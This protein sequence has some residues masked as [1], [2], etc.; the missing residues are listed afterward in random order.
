MDI[1]KE[2]KRMQMWY[3]ECRESGSYYIQFKN[4]ETTYQLGLD[5]IERAKNIAKLAKDMGIEIDE[6]GSI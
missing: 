2:T 4:N 5:L 6:W 3:D 1:E